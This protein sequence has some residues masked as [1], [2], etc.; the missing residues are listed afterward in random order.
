MT[1]QQPCVRRL[2]TA[3]ALAML[4]GAL[5][6]SA[7]GQERAETEAVANEQPSTFEHRLRAF[8]VA[9]NGKRFAFDEAPVDQ[10]G[11]PLYGNPFITQGFIY[12]PGTLQDA[13]GDGVFTGVIIAKDPQTGAEI[14]TP[15]FPD[16]VLGLWICEGK[17]VAQ[18]GFNIASGPTV[19]TL[20]LYEF[21]DMRG[22]FGTSSFL[23]A[24]LELIDVGKGIERAIIGGTGPFKTARGQ[25][26]QTLLGTNVTQGFVLRFE[27][28]MP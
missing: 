17:V 22:D 11:L 8:E 23:S 21:K 1:T 3:V 24:G 18:E 28:T 16:K 14:V 5:S 25:V 15:E 19:F 4:V 20:Q 7:H 9:E 13:D 6:L 2:L 10:N 12:P 27:T 26:T